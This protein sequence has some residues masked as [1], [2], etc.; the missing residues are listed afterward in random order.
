[1]AYKSVT[2]VFLL[3]F[4]FSCIEDKQAKHQMSIAES[5]MDNSP[6]SAFSV[7]SDL[8][9]RKSHL[10]RSQRMRLELLYAE[11]MNKAGVHLDNDSVLLDVV[12]YYDTYGDANERVLARYLL[13]RTYHDLGEIPEALQTYLE[14]LESAD[15]LDADCNYDVLTSV[16]GQMFSITSILQKKNLEH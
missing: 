6:D 8:R 7:L 14:A 10:S 16:L 11:S 5:I 2:I 1:M 4:M 13:G 9:E 3:F 15:T 12:K